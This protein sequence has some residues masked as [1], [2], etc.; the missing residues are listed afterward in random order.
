MLLL[1]RGKLSLVWQLPSFLHPPC[2]SYP[3]TPSGQHG[4][5]KRQIGVLISPLGFIRASTSSS[6]LQDRSTAASGRRRRRGRG[7]AREDVNEASLSSFVF[8]AAAAVRAFHAALAAFV[9]ALASPAFSAAAV[10]TAAVL[11][12]GDGRTRRSRGRVTFPFPP[13]L[14]PSSR[15]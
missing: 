1:P 8:K 3:S 6:S 15:R 11:P 5:R 9:L 13:A 4:T 14:L 10:G 7:R 12:L 2:S